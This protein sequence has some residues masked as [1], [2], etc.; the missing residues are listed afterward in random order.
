[1]SAL[2]VMPFFQFTHFSKGS[3]LGGAEVCAFLT[4][5]IQLAYFPKLNSFDHAKMLFKT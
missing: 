4:N 2:I 5:G 3:N 1:M